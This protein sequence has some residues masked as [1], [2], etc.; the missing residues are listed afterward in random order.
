MQERGI[1]AG[2]CVT[3]KDLVNDPHLISREY[4]W[5][6]AN[7]QAPGVGPRVFAGRPVRDSRN[8]MS[9]N[10][11]AGL[12]QDNGTILSE[13]AGL[14]QSE[15]AGLEADGVIFGAPRPDEPRP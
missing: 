10:K 14:S 13:L 9:L 15:I 6:F 11:V 1:T 8:P 7:P 3:A 4:L 5:E 2:A 12:G